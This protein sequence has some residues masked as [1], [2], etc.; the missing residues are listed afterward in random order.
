MRRTPIRTAGQT[1]PQGLGPA[2]REARRA[3][4]LTQAE[5]AAKAG[6][7]RQKLIELEQGKP[8][9]AVGT[10]LSALA[11]LGLEVTVR[12]KR[13]CL[14]DYPQ[15]RRLAWNRTGE[16][17]VS[18]TEALA[19]YERNWHLVDEREMP[20]HERALLQHLVATHGGGVLHV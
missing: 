7:H 20:P 2:L 11:A 5:L 19:L 8:G 17:S 12:P 16:A 4:R 14:D 18:E 9:V 3:A 6:I 13:I 10:Y 1:T 15:L